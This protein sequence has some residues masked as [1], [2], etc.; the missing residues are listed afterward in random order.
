V[1][2]FRE[3]SKL[4]EIGN[5]QDSLVSN[6]PSRNGSED[7]YIEKNPTQLRRMPSIWI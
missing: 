6:F 3:S 5:Q 2:N 4:R 7:K 1:S